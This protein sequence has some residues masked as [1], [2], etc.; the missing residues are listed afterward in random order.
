M[1]FLLNTTI[2]M[3]TKGISTQQYCA[4][5]CIVYIYQHIGHIRI[6]CRNYNRYEAWVNKVIYVVLFSEIGALN[7]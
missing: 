7:S 3:S 1:L 6:A 5:A 4:C 2:I